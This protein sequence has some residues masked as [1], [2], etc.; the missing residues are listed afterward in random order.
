MHLHIRPAVVDDKP[1]ILDLAQRLVEF[2]SVP[3]RESAAMI[4]R[5]RAVLTNALD[6]PAPD[7]GIFVAADDH[8]NAVGFVHLTSADDYYSSSE[9]AHIADVVV[10][11][12]A[13]GQGIG[14]ALLAYA[15]DWA[16]ERGVAMLTLNVFI[17]NRRARK[18]YAK[19]GFQ[20]EWI[21]CIK[22]L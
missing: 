11:P 10:A 7:G 12:T 5:D 2:G 6:H 15:E 22:R 17:A 14:S 3:G 20:E 13:G 4:A 8:G 16:R 19:L 18:L 21:R 9:T 1:F